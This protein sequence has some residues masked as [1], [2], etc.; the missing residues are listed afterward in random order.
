MYRNVAGADIQEKRGGWFDTGCRVERPI[1]I[2]RAIVIGDANGEIA[3]D[4][5]Y[6]GV[7]VEYNIGIVR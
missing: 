4:L 3:R 5:A 6:I 7:R 2:H 1:V